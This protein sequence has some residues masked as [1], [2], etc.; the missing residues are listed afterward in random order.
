MK[1]KSL[2]NAD[3]AAEGEDRDSQQT[4]GS[5]KR[6]FL[7][8]GEK[9]SRSELRAEASHLVAKAR[10][11]DRV[12]AVS[13]LREAVR[14][15]RARAPLYP[16]EADFLAD[17]IDEAIAMP[18]SAAKALGLAFPEGRPRMSRG[19]SVDLILA[20]RAVHNLVHDPTSP[21]PLDDGQG[22][23]D[24]WDGVGAISRVIDAQRRVGRHL[25]KDQVRRGY[26]RYNE[27]WQA[28]SVRAES[29]P[30]GPSDDPPAAQ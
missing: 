14:A 2:Q 21:V 9:Y 29:L 11:G 22:A 6:L 13:L 27:V 5:V 23:D 30:D 25:T 12:S 19:K 15:L 17:A 7:G 8:P 1:D 16:E 18:K 3:D 10:G 4:A 20:G 28:L 24:G 26:Q